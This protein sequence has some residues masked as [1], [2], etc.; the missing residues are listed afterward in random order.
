MLSC[1]VAVAIAVFLP[2]G[3]SEALPNDPRRAL[4]GDLS[5]ILWGTFGSGGGRR[6]VAGGRGWGLGAGG[7]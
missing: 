6:A 7:S 3:T 4:A 5:G 1:R 2:G